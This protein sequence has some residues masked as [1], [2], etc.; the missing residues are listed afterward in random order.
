VTLGLDP[1]QFVKGSQ[2]ADIAF[3]KVRDQALKTGKQIEESTK[4]TA[5]AFGAVTRGA[6][7]FLAALL[8]AR[9]LVEFTEKVTQANASLGR[10]SKN[11]NVSP[12]LLGAWG[13]AAERLG[14][15]AD[16]TKQS[17]LGLNDKIGA[18]KTQ[19]QALP[20]A[21]YQI[22]TWGGKQVDLNH[23][24]GQSFSDLAAD[25]QHIAQT[26][27]T[28][29]ASFLGRQL[30]LD[31]ATVNLMIANGAKIT[32]VVKDLSK[33]QPS[34]ADIQR[35]QQLAAAWF[36][37]AQSGE[38]FGNT[39]VASITPALTEAANATSSLLNSIR[40]KAEADAAAHKGMYD[41][42][43]DQ[44]YSGFG[45]IADWFLK[46]YR[47]SR[48]PVDQSYGSESDGL[49]V[50]DH[51]VTKGNPMP[52]TIEGHGSGL[53]SG[54]LDSLE[55]AVGGGFWD[56]VKSAFHSLFGGHGGGGSGSNEPSPT[57]AGVGGWWTPDRI[58]HATDR[59]MKEAHLSEPGAAGLVARWAGVESA[60]GPTSSNNIGGGHE[61][62]GQWD[63][64]RGGK[65][66]ASKDFD[67]QLSHAIQELN[68]T[69]VTAATKLRYATTPEEGAVGASMYER[70]EGYNAATG[71]DYFTGRTPTSKILSI[72]HGDANGANPAPDA[73]GSGSAGD[74]LHNRYN[75]LTGKFDI[76]FT[77]DAMGGAAR[78]SMLLPSGPV[79]NDNSR[80]N[81]TAVNIG[82]VNIATQA[83]DGAGVARD[84]ANYTRHNF[85]AMQA[86]Y[87]IA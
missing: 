13:T 22:Q 49:K 70:A 12:Q 3:T 50:N 38:K 86:D 63:S 8:G 69:E 27:G 66:M 36:S 73:R 18:L 76:P 53:G 16:A 25:L 54:F 84:F 55:D 64:A 28:D 77:P 23:G 82:A 47:G 15:S 85:L 17:F 9:G 24:I 39:L 67:T 37:L 81:S 5:E 79:S 78:S 31:D 74:A 30:G 87:G 32:D 19:G 43:K 4:K 80:S 35:S 51:P 34:D 56:R 65:G 21:F 33:L 14:G 11:L 59:L 44:N 83:N 7:M 10:L 61:G 2:D 71:R 26:M 20:L 58:K 1:T 52:V 42:P 41:V 48:S 46:K 72:M 75:P 62:L 68:T 6:G 29:K 40:Q 57:S 60:G 45:Y